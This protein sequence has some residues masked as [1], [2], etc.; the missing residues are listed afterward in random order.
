[1]PWTK[2]ALDKKRMFNK[3]MKDKLKNDEITRT[4]M[5]RQGRLF[6]LSAD[7]FRLCF[8]SEKTTVKVNLNKRTIEVIK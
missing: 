1:M 2:E 4:E 6:D 7:K 8:P 3:K 5:T